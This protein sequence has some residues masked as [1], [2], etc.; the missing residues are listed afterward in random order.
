MFTACV[1]DTSPSLY[2]RA[3]GKAFEV[4]VETHTTVGMA[5]HVHTQGPGMLALQRFPGVGPASPPDL[6]APLERYALPACTNH[7]V[8]SQACMLVLF[9]PAHPLHALLLLL[10]TGVPRR[11]CCLPAAGQIINF[12]RAKLLIKQICS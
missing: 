5:K 8:A 6:S 3:V 4:Q 9:M 7:S 1:G 10:C 12:L 11:L 2:A